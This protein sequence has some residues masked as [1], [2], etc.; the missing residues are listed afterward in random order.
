M[1]QDN[2]RMKLNNLFAKMLMTVL[3]IL[4]SASCKKSVY[5]NISTSVQPVGSGSIVATPSSN[6]V[7]EGTSVSFM[8]TPNGDYVFTGWS[9]SLSGTDNPATVVA[10]SDL[11]IVANF[12]LREYPLTLSVEGEGSI[13]ERVVSTK[14]DYPSGT[15]VELTA[16]AAEHWFFDHWE[17]DVSGKGNPAQITISS[18]KTVKAVFV[19]KMYDLTVTVEGEGAVQEKV[20]ETKGSYQEGTVVELTASPATGWS[21]DHWEGDLSG[22]ENPSQ[23]TVSAAKSVKAVFTK[24]KYP[25]NL[26]IVGP[27][28]VDEFLV[29]DT[30][31][32]L[33]YGARVL[34]KAIPADNAVFK[35]WRGIEAGNDVEITID[36]DKDLEITAEFVGKDVL[37][38]PL[39]D[40]TQPSCTLEKLY[41]GIDLTPYSQVGF[42]MLDYN[43]DGRLDLVTSQVDY[44]GMQARRYPIHFYLG[45]SD[46]SLDVDGRNDSRFES[47]DCRKIV[48]GDFNNDGFPDIFFLGHGYDAE[49]WPGEY[50]I[51]L[52]SKGGPTYSERRFT[53][54]VSFFHGGA[55][56]DIDADGDLD[57]FLTASWHGGGY[58]FINDGNGNFDIRTDLINQEL[59]TSMYTSELF[60]IDHDGF[61]DLF[62][63]G[64]DH[65][66][67]FDYPEGQVE[68]KNMPIV[69]WGDGESFKNDNLI[70]LPKPPKPYGVA[71]DYYFYDLNSDGSEEVI[72]VRTSDGAN[73]NIPYEGWKLQVLERNGRE[74]KDVTDTYFSESC[75]SEAGF[76]IDKVCIQ[77][78]DGINYLLAQTTLGPN[79]VRLYSFTN[80]HFSRVSEERFPKRTNGVSISHTV[81]TMAQ[82]WGLYA[83]LCYPFEMGLD[84]TSLVENDYCVEFYLSNT[85]PDLRFDIH[86]DTTELNSDGEMIMY[87]YGPDLS[88]FKHDGSWERVVIPLKS[89]ELWDDSNLNYWNRISQF[90]IITT[91]TGGTEFS[92]KDIRIR[93]V[94]PDN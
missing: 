8:A 22:T 68:Y 20:V 86:F 43:R 16:K 83:A 36:I 85:D 57:V 77:D 72:V 18:A 65:E 40:L 66:G 15:V 5:Y 84:L 41:Y 2:S 4:G 35:G 61:V 73:G 94:L 81:S 21:F 28:V 32:M 50:P 91:S 75:D 45:E 62:L 38:Y 55:T 92:V 3:V 82:G 25:Y 51:V 89:I 60:D 33:D 90:V 30:K 44:E 74:F 76:W 17:G 7:L 9:G 10:S 6:S 59:V 26:K 53:D 54:I 46:G 11:N 88:S 1:P 37:S 14:T 39:V 78:I 27:G 12:Q 47:I 48:Y 87:G 49:P 80:G 70:R 19:K 63:G 52:L 34:L 79:P 24:N 29:E 42:V 64:H 13:Q 56:G 93:K 69:F 31:A 23:I 67:P 58:F 71:L